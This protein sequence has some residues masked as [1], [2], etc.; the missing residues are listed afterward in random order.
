MKRSISKTLGLLLLAP[1]LFGQEKQQA[2]APAEKIAYAYHGMLLDSDLKPIEL[3]AKT[4]DQIQGSMIRELMKESDEATRKSVGVMIDELSM[5]DKL[6]FDAN[7]RRLLNDAI[8]ATLLENAPKPARDRY[9]WR[10]RLVRSWSPVSKASPQAL[11]WLQQRKIDFEDLIL[12]GGRPDYLAECRANRV[13]IPPDWPSPQ[14]GES[15]GTLPRAFVASGYTAELYAYQDPAVPG[16]CLALP[17]KAGSSIQALGIIC[18]GD[19]RGKAC[20]WDNIDSATG[21]RLQGEDLRL[22][23]ANLQNGSSLAE[24]CTNC[25]RGDNAFLVHP[26]DPPFRE[27]LTRFDLAP[28]ARYSPIGQSHWSNPGPLYFPTPQLPSRTC[29]ECHEIPEPHSS[30]DPYCRVLQQASMQTMPRG[31]PPVGWPAPADSPF[32]TDM[33]FLVGHCNLRGRAAST[34]RIDEPDRDAAVRAELTS[35]TGTVSVAPERPAETITEVRISLG[36]QESDEEWAY[37]AAR[38]TY[39]W[40]TGPT[41]QWLSTRFDGTSWWSAPSAAYTLPGGSDLPDGNYVVHAVL[42]T[43]SGARSEQARRTFTIR[44]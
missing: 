15:L 20:F 29:A 40:M 41:G 26:E 44:R 43:G 37:D 10:Y 17:R 1:V 30:G 21:A 22:S 23:I 7:D 38:R 9:E 2:E 28:R 39:R 13:P 31:G 18:Q 16:V 24:N 6:G 12:E 35:I 27:A 11:E 4:V 3:D 33:Q 8:I 32:S 34:V 19:E 36:R 5:A 42:L 14:W 25:H